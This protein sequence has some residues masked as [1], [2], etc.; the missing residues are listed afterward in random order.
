M[1]KYFLISF[2]LLS[3]FIFFNFHKKAETNIKN[4]NVYI[5]KNGS[6]VSYTTSNKLPTAG[7]K[8][9]LSESSCTNG[10]TVTQNISTK[11]VSVTSNKS[12][13]CNL[14]FDEYYPDILQAN[15]DLN[16][17]DYNIEDIIDMGT[18]SG[19]NCTNTVAFDKTSDENLRYVG[20]RPCNYVTFNGETAGWRII[21]VMNNVDDGNGNLET[22]LKLQRASSIGSFSW[23]SYTGMYMGRGINDWT[24]ADLM[25]ELNTDFLDP[26]LT[27]N[28][29]WFNGQNDKREAEYDRTQSLSTDAQS[30]IGNAKWY[31]G[32]LNVNEKTIREYYDTE[33]GS[34]TYSTNHT[35]N[36]PFCPRATSWIGKVAL[37]YPSDFVYSIGD[38]KRANCYPV[39]N[40]CNLSN[41]N[42]LSRITATITPYSGAANS[43]ELVQ[44]SYI[45]NDI[46]CANYYGVY[47]VVYL[48]SN[49]RI[50]SGSGTQT[51]PYEFELNT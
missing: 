25:T 9:N 10:A 30:L 28:P 50:K 27:S 37:I 3:G 5:E 17:N 40:S 44:T 21:G 29:L 46:S 11:K 36:D 49:I 42:Y 16:S 26:T 24:Q 6:Y 4:Y 32:G 43:F 15:S 47:P 31:L 34:E 19:S 18:L 41:A 20:A 39:E 8:L 48:K 2:I 35:C 1:K 7:Y 38:N 51:N 45:R 13:V 12:A 14:Y 22:R 23:D 33:R